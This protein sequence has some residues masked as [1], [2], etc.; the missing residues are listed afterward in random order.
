MKKRT[1]LSNDISNG[2]GQSYIHTDEISVGDHQRQSIP[3]NGLGGENQNIIVPNINGLTQIDENQEIIYNGAANDHRFNPLEMSQLNPMSMRE[4]TF[5]L[6]VPLAKGVCCGLM[7]LRTAL[8][9]IAFVDIV[10]G[11]SGIAIAIMAML[12]SNLELQLA[13]YC[14]VL[15]ICFFLAIAALVAIAK[16]KIKLMK[17]Y[18][19]WKCAEVFI[20]PIFEI[21]IVFIKSKSG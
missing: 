12:K 15:T 19:T 8:I 14:I 17:I 7:S 4:P 2:G 18:F 20:L 13:A 5:C 1:N 10:M 3:I 11:G 16:K 6:C 9:I 21:V